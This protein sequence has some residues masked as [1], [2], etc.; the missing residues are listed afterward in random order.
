MEV[1]DA[2]APRTA[3]FVD[4]VIAATEPEAAYFRGIGATR[5][6]RIPSGVDPPGL[7]ASRED[8]DRIRFEVGVGPRDPLVLIVGRDNS[9][10]GLSFGLAS[11]SRLR[12]SLPA[13]RLV[14]IGPEHRPSRDGVSRPGWLDAESL[15][16]VYRA[17]D[18]LFVPSLYE[19]QPRV[20]MEAWRWGIPVVVT[21]RVGLAQTVRQVGGAVT[22]FGDPDAAAR[23]LYEVL[24]DEPRA[25]A[26]GERGRQLVVS[27]FLTSTVVD[28]TLELYREVLADVA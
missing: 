21:D 19:Q 1:F 28:R 5:V 27:E 18:V 10:K 14:L 4:A 12:R 25:R 17:A 26:L 22:P 11:F 8:R 15:S 13:A 20:V 9:R 7:P 24:T 3:R 23:A 2:V 16:R 6:A